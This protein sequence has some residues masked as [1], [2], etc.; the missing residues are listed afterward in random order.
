MRGWRT[1]IVI[2]VFVDFSIGGG[3]ARAEVAAWRND[4]GGW[5]DV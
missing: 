3:N 2:S 5:D 1:K 4:R